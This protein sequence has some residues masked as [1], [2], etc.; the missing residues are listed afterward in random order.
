[1]HDPFN[2]GIDSYWSNLTTERI[3]TRL[4]DATLPDHVV[5]LSEHRRPFLHLRDETILGYLDFFRRYP[6]ALGRLSQAVKVAFDIQIPCPLD[7]TIK[8]SHFDLNSLEPDILDSLIPL[9]FEPDHFATLNPIE[10][11]WC[12]TM[13]MEI[14]NKIP[15]YAKRLTAIHDMMLQNSLIAQR[16]AERNPDIFGYL[17]VETYCS[18]SRHVLPFKTI[19]DEGLAAFPFESGEFEQIEPP[20][21][22]AEAIKFG[23]PLNVHKRVDI[24][25]KVPTEA[26]GVSFQGADSTSM[27]RL[28]ELFLAAGFYEIYSE[29]GNHI[30]TVQ[31]LD[32][33]PGKRIFNKLRTWAGIFGGIIGIKMEACNYFYRTPRSIQGV[34]TLAPIPNLTKWRKAA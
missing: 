31:L 27:Q 28:R 2:N 22:H 25:V 33:Q 11:K 29:A 15:N 12:L 9:G 6:E 14:A 7:Y 26:R 24:H 17:E 5:P 8:E 13:K 1:M 30:Y 10:Y 32:P 23:I 19:S 16:I 3:L 21:T 20:S 18:K 4:R 34:T